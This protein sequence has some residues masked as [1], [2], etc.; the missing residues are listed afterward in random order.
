MYRLG[1]LKFIIL[2]SFL[3]LIT[4]IVIKFHLYNLND[5]KLLVTSYGK[6]APFIF[7]LLCILRPILLLPIGLFSVLGGILFGSVKGTVLTVL[8]STVGSI[9]AYYISWFLGA[10]F[11]ERYFGD[12]IKKYSFDE[13]NAFKITFLMRVI[14]I[15][16]CD[17]VSYICGLSRINIIKYTLASFLGI[18]PGTFI[19]SNFGSSLNNIYSRQFIFSVVMIILLSLIPLLLKIQHK[20]NKNNEQVVKSLLSDI[21]NNN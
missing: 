18:I 19:Y 21:D 9:I 10:D 4:I 17:V 8:G 3:T 2:T 11:F 15:L 5:V 13:R 20:G 14:P 1:N 12:K 6:L 7:F 16:P